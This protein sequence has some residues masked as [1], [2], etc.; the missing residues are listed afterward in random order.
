MKKFLN[1]KIFVSLITAL[2]VGVTSVS[3]TTYFMSK[4]VVYDNSV[5]GLESSDVQGA[6]DELY[7]VC[8]TPQTP[9]TAGEEILEKVE[10]V[11][12][13]DGLYVD[14][15]EDGK[16]TYKGANPNNYVTF[17]NENAGW[18]IVSINPDKTIKIMKVGSV[19]NRD[20][21]TS[22]SNNWARPADLNTYLTGTY[23][24]EL[25]EGAKG[26]IVADSYNI[27]AVNYNNNDMQDQINDE[28]S[29]QWY[30][31]I[32]LPTMSEYIRASS[33]V[34][35][36]THNKY[37]NNYSTCKNSNWTVNNE[38]WW[39]LS[40]STGTSYDVFVVYPDGRAIS[41]GGS[42]NY[43]NGAGIRPVVTIAYLVQIV[44]G[45][46]SRNNPIILE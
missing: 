30:G 35:C 42:N 37:N 14:E 4:D 13:G 16:Y 26:Q 12:S 44:G 11:T 33:N 10:I 2:I 31:S 34:N 28:K 3:A 46:G 40:P 18:R 23:Y 36:K 8:S 17:N 19:G 5:S 25:S 20:W 7:A 38:Y 41:G 32:A 1:G 6:I 43:G 15:Y 45:D 29:Q 9:P 39:T 27:G 24:N 22:A 21:S